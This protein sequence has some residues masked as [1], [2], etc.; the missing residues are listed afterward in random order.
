MKLSLNQSLPYSSSIND[1]FEGLQTKGKRFDIEKIKNFSLTIFVKYLLKLFFE[2][3]T[4]NFYY[5][6]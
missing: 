6:S 2:A 5:I 1:N 4:K 3:M